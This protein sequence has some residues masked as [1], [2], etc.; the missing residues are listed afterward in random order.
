MLFRRRNP[1]YRI[2]N[3]RRKKEKEKQNG[4]IKR[5]WKPTPERKKMC[6]RGSPKRSMR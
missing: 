3:R 1:R 4:H 2:R 5:K 6:K